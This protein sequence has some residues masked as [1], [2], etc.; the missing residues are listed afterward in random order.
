MTDAETAAEQ[1]RVLARVA[2][3]RNG[4]LAI[5]WISRRQMPRW[6]MLLVDGQY[7]NRQR[8]RQLLSRKPDLRSA[9]GSKRKLV[10]AELKA[11]YNNNPWRLYRDDVVAKRG[12]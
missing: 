11:V 2:R 3:A 5:D 7:Y 6:R 10:P 9:P 12:A 4:R 8:L 1:L